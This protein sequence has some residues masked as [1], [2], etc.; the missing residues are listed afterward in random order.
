MNDLL[1]RGVKLQLSADGRTADNWTAFKFQIDHTLACINLDG[2]YLDDILANKRGGAKPADPGPAA[3]DWIAE[4]PAARDQAGYDAAEAK[5]IKWKRASSQALTIIMS[6][7]PEELH[8]EA[9]QHSTAETLWKYLTERFSSQSMISLALIYGKLFRMNINAYD[10]VAA[11][12]TALNKIEKE[13]K[14]GGGQVH[15]SLLAGVIILAMG[16]NW[17]LAR[18]LMLNMPAAEQ[19]VENFSKRLLQ[20]EK[21]DIQQQEAQVS[22]VARHSGSSSYRDNRSPRR[23]GAVCGYVRKLQGRLD[24]QT[25]GSK[26]TTTHPRHK[27]WAKKDDE[28]LQ[29][30]PNKTSEQLP[31][32]YLENQSSPG[33]FIG[34][35]SPSKL[36][37]GESP[38]RS[39]ISNISNTSNT[40]NTKG[41][42]VQFANAATELASASGVQDLF[43]SAMMLSD[44]NVSLSGDNDILFEYFSAPELKPAQALSATAAEHQYLNSESIEVLSALPRSANL[45]I[46]DNGATRSC[47]NIGVNKQLLDVPVTVHGAYKGCDI[48]V[49][50]TA[51][52]PCPHLGHGASIRGFWSPDFRHN[53][54][55]VR[56]IQ[57]GLHKEVTFPADGK[58]ALIKDP[59]TQETLWIFKVGSSG[60][61][62]AQVP[63]F[64]KPLPAG[65]FSTIIQ[66]THADH[67]TSLLHQRLG[68]I[69]DKYLQHLIQ[70]QAIQGLPQQ[71]EAP[72]IPHHTA[73]GTCIQSKAKHVPHNQKRT[74]ALAKLDLL[75]ADLVGPLPVTSVNGHRYWLTLVDDHTRHGWSIPL[76]SKDL[77]A[78]TIMDWVTLQEKQTGALF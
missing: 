24:H 74:R 53:L 19:T 65:A 71:Y 60:L 58:Q 10:N 50:Y 17:P 7:L 40:S 11:F 33:K 46:L 32:W 55:S 63:G 12:L 76:K 72:P 75:H 59:T 70:H 35:A 62:E 49:N 38:R 56:D 77:A 36:H 1:K 54:I 68:H 13:I 69:S 51:E 52:I 16:S 67:P 61:Y 28:W 37:R 25:P 47:L 4:E 20:A 44:N 45:L 27:C 23:D 64:T 8:D 73:C 57:Q 39:N 5:F 18:E 34:S 78:E 29:A 43:Q 41:K 15:T 31:N 9:A 6:L 21:N 14:D 42:R 3:A 48:T 26:C 30:H 66:E 22:A 2:I